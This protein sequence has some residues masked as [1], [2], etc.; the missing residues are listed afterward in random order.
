M[1]ALALARAIEIIGEAASRLSPQMRATAPAVPWGRIVS[2]RNRLVHAY[3]NIDH[4]ILW[5]TATEE[6]PA[7]LP[8]LRT[9]ANQE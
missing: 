1:L 5:S 3:F 2:M 4:D 8:V 9:L 6:V 7:P